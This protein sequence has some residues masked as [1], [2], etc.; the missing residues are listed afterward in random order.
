MYNARISRDITDD[1]CHLLAANMRSEEVAEVWASSGRNP[2]E[3]VRTSLDRSWDAFTAWQ[4]DKLLCMSGVY[5]AS[6][7]SNRGCPWL[8]TT[9]DMKANPRA[10][11]HYS[12]QAV[13]GW[14]DEFLILTQMVDARYEQ[15]VRW[16]K[17]VGFTVYPPEPFGPLDLPFHRIEIRSN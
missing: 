17:W 9:N 8:L 15:S 6:P 16:A 1:D 5:R 4:D 14:L 2:Y 12:K 10:L 3:A 7:V 13:T 11:L